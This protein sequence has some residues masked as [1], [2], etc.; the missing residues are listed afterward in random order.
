MC[1]LLFVASSLS[2]GTQ[3][4]V[5]HHQLQYSPYVLRR[6]ACN[7]AVEALLHTL[8]AVAIVVVCYINR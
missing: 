2:R 8:N 1:Q 3:Q 6:A 7:L 4:S 5:S